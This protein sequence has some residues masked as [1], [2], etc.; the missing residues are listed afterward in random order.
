MANQP[1][2]ITLSD[3][4]LLAEYISLDKF[5]GILE[6]R[7]SVGPDMLAMLIKDG[8]IAQASAGAHFAIGGVWRSLKDAIAGQH[9]IRL[10]IADLKP[11]Q[12]TTTRGLAEQGQ[13]P[14]RRRVHDR[15]AGQSR[16][17]GERPRPD[18]GTRLGHQEQRARAAC[19]RTSA[20]AC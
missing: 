11:F 17:A 19:R 4:N 7:I 10:L 16:E 20:T 2:N 5:K 13:R 15:A 6:Q 18:E 9:A 14:G 8:Q 1:T 12:L 3:D